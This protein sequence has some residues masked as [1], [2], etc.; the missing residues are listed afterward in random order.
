MPR[1]RPQNS[2]GFTGAYIPFPKANSEEHYF[3]TSGGMLPSTESFVQKSLSDLT[4]F[5]SANQANIKAP[6]VEG[7][8]V[9]LQTRIS[10]TVRVGTIP[11]WSKIVPA[12]VACSD[13]PN[14]ASV[15]GS[16]SGKYDVLYLRGHCFEGADFLESSDHKIKK[17]VA[18]I[19]DEMEGDLD[20]K[21]AC[22]IKIFACESGAASKSFLPF[23]S[24]SAFTQKFADTMCQKGWKSCQFFG[25]EMELKTTIPWDQTH[26]L[27]GDKSQRAS[28][29]RKQFW[30]KV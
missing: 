17:K 25:Y 27:T 21:S 20:K 6:A 24:S 8:L 3:A 7:E 18:E 13:T 29:V 12:N 10:D 1:T 23:L 22:I 16:A 15:L 11:A 30:P 2:G 9:R 14:K 19:V 5:V 4:N 28:A 26:K